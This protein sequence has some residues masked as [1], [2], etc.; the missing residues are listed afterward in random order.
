MV[1]GRVNEIPSVNSEDCH[2]N[3]METAAENLYS[4]RHVPTNDDVS[5][6]LPFV[7]SIRDPESHFH[8]KERNVPARG[9]FFKTIMRSIEYLRITKSRTHKRWHLWL[10]DSMC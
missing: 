1:D 8:Y 5:I 6:F 7:T 2:E 4:S 10:I 9:T 3:E